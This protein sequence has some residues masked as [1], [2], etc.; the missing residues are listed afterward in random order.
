MK[1]PLVPVALSLMA[2]IIVALHC[3]WPGEAWLWAIAVCALLIGASLLFGRRIRWPVYILSVLF[4]GLL[5]GWLTSRSI[6]QDWTHKCQE[7]SFLEVKLTET[8]MPRAKSWRVKG[9]VTRAGSAT[10]QP[11][12]GTITVYLRK[13]SV[14]AILR[15]GDQ[16][17]LHGYPDLERRNIYITSDH[18]LIT[19][20]DSTSL[21]ARCERI[22]M[23]LLRRMQTGP[24]EPREAALAETMT[25][26]WR[27]DLDADTQQHF[28]D[29]GIAHLLSVSGLHV[30]L[31]AAIVGLFLFWI[32]KERRGRAIRGGVQ[33]VVIWCFALLSGMAPSTLRA[34]LMFSLFIVANISGR[35]TPTLNLLAAAAIITLLI[36]PLVLKEVGWQLSY[37][38]VCGLILAR[39]AIVAFRNRL[40]QLVS[41]SVFA[42]LATL[43]IVATTFHRLPVYFL[44]ANIIIIPLAGV[45][46]FLS[47]MYMIV[48]CDITAWPLHWLTLGIEYVTAWVSSLP[49]AVVEI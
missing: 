41:V 15:Y 42:T 14:A 21:R 30:G 9:E 22:R 40:W 46:L 33:L 19:A 13:D 34:A 47:L 23:K 11:A 27:G 16:L 35:R 43:P 5:G 10:V 28:R 24:L 1:T 2:G 29:S 31:L 3:Q 17:L 49:G 6:Q 18:Y 39:P 48:P 32:G 4:S 8:P 7:S 36:N 45:L 37:S 12:S 44:I 26:G 20:R 38:A 25:L